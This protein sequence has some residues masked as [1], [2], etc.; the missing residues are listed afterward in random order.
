V[1]KDQ[2]QFP[3]SLSG[4]QR[5]GTEL[6]DAKGLSDAG[7]AGHKKKKFSQN[8]TVI[9]PR[10]G[11][12]S[13]MSKEDYNQA[14]TDLTNM[15]KSGEAAKYDAGLAE[16]RNKTGFSELSKREKKTIKIDSSK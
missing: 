13:P 16:Q 1:N 10:G 15:R 3:R 9:E 5:R 6:P 12:I 8:V 7:L 2:E 11:V 4:F 14:S